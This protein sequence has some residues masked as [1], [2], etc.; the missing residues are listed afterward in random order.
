LKEEANLREPIKTIRLQK[1]PNF[2]HHFNRQFTNALICILTS[3]RK[4]LRQ[5][6]VSANIFQSGEEVRRVESHEIDGEI[7][8]IY[9]EWRSQFRE[10]GPN[11]LPKISNLAK[12]SE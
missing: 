8:S 4:T 9:E 3:Q 5:R 12:A 2:T 1:P 10:R 6:R 11:K 7:G